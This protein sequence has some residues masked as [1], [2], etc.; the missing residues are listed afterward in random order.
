[1]TYF[2]IQSTLLVLVDRKIVRNQK[3]PAAS[4]QQAI[5]FKLL[6]MAYIASHKSITVAAQFTVYFG[7]MR[8]L[9]TINTHYILFH[10]GGVLL[11]ISALCL[12]HLAQLLR[13]LLLQCSV[14][15]IQFYIKTF[16][17]QFAPTHFGLLE[18]IIVSLTAC[19]S[20]W[21]WSVWCV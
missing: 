1:M 3:L 14:T 10:R 9:G 19:I 5:S 21:V 7:L 17:F 16:I 4:A 18:T 11:L 2:V 13:S 8:K 12:H 20:L 15:F 6:R